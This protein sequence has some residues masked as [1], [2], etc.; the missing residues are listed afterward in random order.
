MAQVALD[1][2]EQGAQNLLL[3]CAGAQA[4]DRVLLVGEVGENLYFETE[5][6]D[7]VAEVAANLGMKPEVVL[8]KPVSDATEFPETV[9]SA[10]QRADRT[11][12]FSRLGD[13]V[14]FSLP[15][16]KAKAV[17]TYTLG[18]QYL[19]APFASADFNVMKQ[20]H[21]ALLDL[22][23]NAKEYSITGA[24]GT[25]LQ[26]RIKPGRADAVA[27][28]ALELFPV[29]IFPPVNCFEMNGTLAIKHFVTSSS[30]RAYEDSTLVLDQPILARVE[31]SRMVDF[32]GPAELVARLKSQLERAAALTGG[33]PYLINSWHTGINPNTFFEGDPYDD[34]ELWGTVAYGSPR[35]THLHAAGIDPGD[36]AFHMMDATISFDG[37]V[38]WDEGRFV[39]LDRPEIQAM[40]TEE[41]RGLLNSSVLHDIGL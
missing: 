15:E 1:R 32:D 22:I 28:F 25:N 36:I 4:G 29:M 37:Q 27:D 38:V 40:M 12:F 31:N 2:I 16:G 41:Q 11:I 17:M 20:M 10:M 14:R 24:C 19:A 18:R 13:Q 23:L 9:N 26:S 35:Y 3:N 39:F 33:D 6:C 5:L 21:D 7:A 34:L 8:A 30:T